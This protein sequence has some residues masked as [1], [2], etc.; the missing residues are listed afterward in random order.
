MK[1]KVEAMGAFLLEPSR[2][3]YPV[4][5]LC[6]RMVCA[7]A[8]YVPRSSSDGW[9]VPLG[10]YLSQKCGVEEGRPSSLTATNRGDFKL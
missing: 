6:F 1:M 9:E 10:W 7:L 2:D 5:S 8:Y 4:F 3:W